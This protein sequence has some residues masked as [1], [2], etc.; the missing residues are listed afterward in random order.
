V[1]TIANGKVYVGTQNA[2][3]IFG[4]LGSGSGQPWTP[5]TASYSGLFAEGGGTEFGR[6]GSVDIKTS[7][8]GSYSGKASLGGKSVAFRGTFDSNGAST[9][10]ASAKGSGTVTFNLQVNTNDNSVITG[11]VGGDGWVANLTANREVL[12]KRS[13]PAPFAGKYNLVFPGGDGDP[14][15]PQNDGTGTLT[16]STAGQVKFKGT[17]GDGTKVSESATVSQE[18]DWPFYIPLYKQGGQIMGWLNFDGTGNV[19]GQTSWIKQPN[20]KSKTF[21]DGFDLNLNATGSAQ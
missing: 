17:L 1:P 3:T 14:T 21:P 20:S 4:S 18:G 10:S 19:G 5:I 11:L 8:R 7:K 12:D 2:V 15:H 9:A 13:N 6:S 16:V